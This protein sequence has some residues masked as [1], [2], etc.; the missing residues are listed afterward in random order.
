MSKAARAI[1]WSLSTALAYPLAGAA[2]DN[3]YEK[4]FDTQTGVDPNNY[5]PNCPVDFRHLKLELLFEDLTSRSFA[6]TATITLRP[7]H[8]SVTTLTL[9]AVDFSIEDVS[10]SGGRTLRYDYDDERL[11]LSFAE[12]LPIDTDTS[13]SI[14][15]RCVEPINGMV[16]AIPDEAYP[17]RP[18][19]IHTQGETEYARYWFPCL[20]YPID[21]CT[22]EIIATVPSPFLAISNGELIHR[23]DDP[24]T[25]RTTFHYR[26]EVPHVFYLVSLVIGRFDE[27]KD[28]WRDIDVQYFVPPGQGELAKLTYG[29]T[30]E[31]MEHFSDLLGYDYPYA[32]YSQ[33]N[34][35]LFLFGGMEN[36]SA[37]TMTDTAL[38]TP[39]AALDQNLEGLISHEL[40]HQ[41]FGDLLTCRGWKHIWLNEGF[42]TFM[43]SVW[44]EQSKGRDDYLYEFWLRFQQVAENDRTDYGAGI[45]FPDYR[46]PF[47]TFWHKGAM[48][49]SKGSC[50]LHML[51]H[52]LGDE[53][54]WRAI[55]AYVRAHAN[56]QVET[57]DL[58][59]AFE[60]VTGRSLEQ[61]FQQWIVRP[62]II[63][64]EVDYDW[65]SANNLATVAATQ[66]QLIERET[67]AFNVP[68][69][70]FF[71][72]GE[73][74]IT[75]TIW[76][77]ERKEVYR[78]TFSHKPDLFCVD[79]NA[80]L[81]MKLECNK[82]RSL[83]LTQLAEGPTTISR[84]VAAKH[85][86]KHNRPEVVEA[87]RA[88]AA[89]QDEH[90]SVRS[91]A[92]A[93]LSAMRSNRARDALLALLQDKAAIADHKVRAAVIEGASGYD[94][95]EVGRAIA[96]FARSDPSSNVEA[97]A[98]TALGQVRAFDAQ[99]I[100]IKNA[101]K[102][103]YSHQIRIA[104][105]EALAERDD[106]PAIDV[107]LKY[108]AYGRHDRVRPVAMRALGRLARD[109]RDRR[110]EIRAFLIRG[111]TDPQHRTV[112]AS[113]D[114][115]ADIGDAESTAALRQLLSGSPEPRAYNAAV[116]ALKRAKPET[117][118]EAVRALRRT[119][120]ELREEVNKLRERLE[121]PQTSGATIQD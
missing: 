81:L 75:T 66:T 59:R 44:K 80:G 18:L 106:P 82:P 19:V 116:D 118:S 8:E 65:D 48:P 96:P 43:A 21:R 27:I 120:D 64:L 3:A 86:A 79:P 113:I 108:A 91:E 121:A 101:D 52:E 38:L 93:A 49:Y 67:P 73:E 32:K 41:W 1:I 13:L 9:N 83:W 20:D 84:C 117:E 10:I 17:N 74:E 87:L 119:V 15:Y 112:L 46:H 55:R 60:T 78:R 61:F 14:R 88:K 68:L 110:R 111:L 95:V 33:V 2:Q 90:W 76:L 58:R 70:L 42:A 107:A 4:P 77:S 85:L 37:T 29:R 35:P 51:R 26:Q 40:A 63:N 12:P 71:R 30:P 54:F 89:Q 7:V 31:M 53:L 5:P 100:L 102:E 23:R 50:V 36:T 22:S 103:S 94:T 24:R 92:A 98:T 25:G 28:K 72:V 45:I 62:G 34:V 57:N 109:H 16:W 56:Q 114:A 6:G 105:I 47:D 104:A 69:D 115:L 39:R 11:F 97:V 99:D